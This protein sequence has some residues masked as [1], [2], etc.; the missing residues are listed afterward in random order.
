[1]V[2]Y[3]TPKDQDPRGGSKTTR[4]ERINDGESDQ[5][6]PGIKA[7]PLPEQSVCVMLF[8]SVLIFNMQPAVSVPDCTAAA[9]MF[10][11]LC[12]SY[13]R[14]FVVASCFGIAEGLTLNLV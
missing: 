8:R 5:Q 2:D 4:R 11:R 10:F 12:L 9:S 1:M 14:V 6:R 7:Q 3:F 13:L